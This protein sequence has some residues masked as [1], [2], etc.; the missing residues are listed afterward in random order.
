MRLFNCN[1]KKVDGKDSQ[2]KYE[3][4]RRHKKKKGGGRTVQRIKRK[5]ALTVRAFRNIVKASS[6]RKSRRE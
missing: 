1:K 2:A 5:L 3:R 6:V 4:P